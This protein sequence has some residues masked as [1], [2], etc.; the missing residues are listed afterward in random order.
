MQ[1]ICYKNVRDAYAEQ[2]FTIVRFKNSISRY[3]IFVAMIT[4]FYFIGKAQTNIINWGFFVLNILN[5][6][7]IAKGDNKPSTNRHSMNIAI[8]IK[9]YSAFMLIFE[10]LFISFVGEMEKTGDPKSLDQRLKK[11]LPSIYNN[12]D[13]IG[14]RLWIKPGEESSINEEERALRLSS[15]FLSYISYLM[16]SIYLIGYFDARLKNDKGLDKYSEEEFKDMFEFES[17]SKGEQRRKDERDQKI[18][19]RETKND[20]GQK[21]IVQ[22]IEINENEGAYTSRNNEQEDEVFNQLLYSKKSNKKE[23]V[24]KTFSHLD[25]MDVYENIRYTTPF[26]VYQWIDYWP[27]FDIMASYGH[28][29]N[30]MIIVLIAINYNVSFF[31]GFNVGC[32]CLFYSIATYKVNKRAMMCYKESG[33]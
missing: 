25:L 33:L 24:K 10:T 16:I 7:F 12:L 17:Q 30:N 11:W 29:F 23:Y 14:L 21:E 19:K 3:M 27:L 2:I 32:V 9:I 28:I 22:E 8:T 6:A 31:M 13:L 4:M 18:K 15:K 5:F 26:V 20:S 1:D